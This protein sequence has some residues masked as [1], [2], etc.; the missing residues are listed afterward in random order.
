VNERPV[1]IVVRD[2]PRRSRLTVFF[3]L[4]LAIPHFFWV[5]VWSLGVFFTVIAQWFITVVRGTP[6]ATLHGF[7][8][9]YVRYL[10]HL[11]A[12][13][14]LAANPYP[15][16]VGDPGYP[17][18]LEIDAAERQRRLT[19]AF[20]LFLALPAILLLAI[21]NGGGVGGGASVFLFGGG[22][23]LTVAVLAWF[24]C[25]VRGSMPLGLRNVQAYGLRYTAEV[26]AYVLLLTDTYPSSDPTL[27]PEAE[28]P[29]EHPIRLEVD[30]DRRRSRLTTFFRL[31]LAL[32]HIVWLVLWS[33]AA[34]LAAIAQWFVTL[35]AGRPAV[36]L[37][38]FLAAFIRY[39]AH[40]TAF[41]GMVANPF[42]G[43]TGHAGYPIDVVVSPPE[44]QNRWIT[45]FRLL[46]ALPAL[47]VN[48]AL[49][50]LLFAAAIGGWFAALAVGRIP[51]GL[52]NAGAHA[53]R[54]AAQ[55]NGYLMLLTD[56]Y[57]FSGPPTAEPPVRESGLGEGVWGDLEVPPAGAAG[58]DAAA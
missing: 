19:A 2:D 36:S 33:V 15:G 27:P 8:T 52:R 49:S 45:G 26:Y 48:G 21:I 32:P 29:P 56:R 12:Y 20:R 42:P 24:V 16:F 41:A 39:Q 10:T 14:A 31:F 7:H 13:L 37:H 46:L 58:T 23:V 57:P 4:L 44:R 54:Y 40:V 3:R 5:G 6:A 1:R 35:F 17:I 34:F 11:G 38:R 55:T 47:I 43:F 50:G 53:V 51:M 18:D 28:A 25:L 9:L 22:I 30:D